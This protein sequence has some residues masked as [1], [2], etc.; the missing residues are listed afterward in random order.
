MRSGIW[1]D[2]Y[3]LRSD[4]YVLRNFIVDEAKWENGVEE[5]AVLK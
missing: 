4:P 3:V 2:P 5:S 1:S